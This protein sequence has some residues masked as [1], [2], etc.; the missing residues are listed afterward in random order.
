MKKQIKELQKYFIDRLI[1]GRYKIVE[2]DEYTVL[3]AVGRYEFVF[4][5][6]NGL[7]YFKQVDKY[8]YLNFMQLDMSS[9]ELEKLYNNLNKKKHGKSI[10]KGN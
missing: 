7:S 3:L 9:A 6:G 10:S 2:A 4:W 5:I 1:A 8:E